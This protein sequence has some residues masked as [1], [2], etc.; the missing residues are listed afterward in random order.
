MFY[1]SPYS[2]GNKNKE[3]GPKLQWEGP[4]LS[5]SD[6]FSGQIM[7]KMK[8]GNDLNFEV[9]FFWAITFKLMHIFHFCF[10]GEKY[11]IDQVVTPSKP[12]KLLLR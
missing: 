10:A 9:N 8:K 3:M 2:N 4:P 12:S 7:V 6:L 1:Y 11:Q 5:K